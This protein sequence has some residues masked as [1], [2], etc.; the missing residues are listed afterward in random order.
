MAIYKKRICVIEPLAIR[1]RCQKCTIDTKFLLNLYM[2]C[3]ATAPI[4]VYYDRNKVRTLLHVRYC[5][6][7]TTHRQFGPSM[8]NITYHVN[9]SSISGRGVIGCWGRHH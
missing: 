7:R 8:K 6:R 5:S 2:Y 1:G 9:C 4:S 3:V